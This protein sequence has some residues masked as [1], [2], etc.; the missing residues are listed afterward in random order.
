MVEVTQGARDAAWPFMDVIAYDG[1]ARLRAGEYDD[2]AFIQAIAEAEARGVQQGLDMAAGVVEEGS[3]RWRDKS[4]ATANKR[5]SRDYET[6]AIACIHVAAAIRK[7]GGG[8]A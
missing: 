8:D 5:E 2:N 6:M 3:S 1:E 4:S 7:L